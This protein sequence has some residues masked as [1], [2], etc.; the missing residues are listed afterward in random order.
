MS[1][2]LKVAANAERLM[3]LRR[4]YVLLLSSYLSTMATVMR[5]ILL[6]SS[7]NNVTSCPSKSDLRNVESMLAACGYCIEPRGDFGSGDEGVE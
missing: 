1:G 7:M 3:L 4:K 5:R 2:L 6:S